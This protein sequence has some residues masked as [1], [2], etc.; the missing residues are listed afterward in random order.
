[1]NWS[2]GIKILWLTR[3]GNYIKMSSKPSNFELYSV[4]VTTINATEARRQQAITAFL[5]ATGASI[6]IFVAGQLSAIF[7]A[8]TMWI[9]SL[10]W[11]ATIRYFRRL[12]KAKFMVIEELER[13]WSIQPF[14]LEWGYF[15]S[16]NP[17]KK[18]QINQYL[19]I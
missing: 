8:V 9:L 3:Y 11:I 17:E 16:E 2:V 7:L 6:A 15:K 12:A 4:Y 1:M 13:T 19:D 10:L 18:I 5:S 14:K